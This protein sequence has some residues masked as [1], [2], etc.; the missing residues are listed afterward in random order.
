[1]TPPDDRPRWSIT[2]LFR[3]QRIGRDR[4]PD[5]P[6]SRFDRWFPWAV[7]LLLMVFI[8]VG[9]WLGLLPR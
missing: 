9:V 1:V 5:G 3:V 2:W 6:P 8:A 7:I 4:S